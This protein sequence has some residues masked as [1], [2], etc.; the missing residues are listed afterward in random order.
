LTTQAINKV[1]PE[2]ELGADQQRILGV[3]GYP[4][5]F[6]VIFDEGNNNARIDSWSYKDIEA[7]FI[8]EDGVYSDYVDYIIEE[9]GATKYKVKPQQFF[10]PMKPSDVE[11]LIGEKGIE[12]MDDI[13]G[14]KVIIFGNGELIC[15]FNPDDILIIANKTL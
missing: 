5:V 10:Y 4:D 13:A 14:L 7:C 9:P 1:I 2:D 12:S 8:F 11:L 3:F 15:I 6:T